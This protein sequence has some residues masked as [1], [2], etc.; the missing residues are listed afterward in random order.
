MHDDSN[1]LP[2]KASPADLSPFI[3]S[4]TWV[5]KFRNASRGL[6]IGILG[7]KK[8]TSPNSFFV[9][10]PAAAIVLTAGWYRGLDSRWMAILCG[11][12]AIVWIAE[13]FNTSI[14]CVARAITNEYHHEIRDAL[15]IASGAVWLASLFAVVVGAIA[16]L[17]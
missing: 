14:E 4:Q 17:G 13:L 11:C 10:I 1:N 12:I 2:D 3:S 6:S 7:R 5:A 9:H 16:F 15:D 8:Q